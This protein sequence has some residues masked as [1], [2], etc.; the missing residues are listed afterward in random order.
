MTIAEAH[1]ALAHLIANG[2]EDAEFVIGHD[3]T[4]EYVTVVEAISTESFLVTDL[5][6]DRRVRVAA[7]WIAQKSPSYEYTDTSDDPT[8]AS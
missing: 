3:E 6:T 7:A 8:D 4:P 2:H 5:D 1:L